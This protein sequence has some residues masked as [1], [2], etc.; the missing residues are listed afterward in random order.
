MWG[1]HS[2]ADPDSRC[3][4][5]IEEGILSVC[6]DGFGSLVWAYSHRSGLRVLSRGW[7]KGRGIWKLS[8]GGVKARQGLM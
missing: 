2:N 1:R 4:D 3:S 5:E 8:G 7:A 6:V